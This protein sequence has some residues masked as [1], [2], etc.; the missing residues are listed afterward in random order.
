MSSRAVVAAILL[1]AFL[2]PP[3]QARERL[4]SD[5]Q[6]HHALESAADQRDAD[7][8]R[9]DGLLRT[10]ETDEAA[11]PGPQLAAR[12]RARLP[13]LS[14]AEL[15]DLATRAEALEQDPA[16]GGAGKVVL[17]SLA[18][19]GGLYVITALTFVVACN[20]RCLD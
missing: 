10:L 12:A 15:R 6:L 5:T 4:V 1:V 16:A 13:L 3:V 9:L 17:V 7:L 14:D 19:I 2:A 11:A 8:D 18:V 20:G